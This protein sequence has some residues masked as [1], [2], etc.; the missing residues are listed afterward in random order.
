MNELNVASFF[1]SKT[2]LRTAIIGSGQIGTDL[3]FKVKSSEIL[4]PACLIGRSKN[5]RGLG[6]ARD[7]GV[8]S[9]SEGIDFLKEHLNQIDLLFDASSA[10]SHPEHYRLLKPDGIPVIDLTPAKLGLLCVPTINLNESKFRDNI[11]MITCGGQASLPMVASVSSA[12]E[13]VDYIEVVSSISA[14][15]AGLATRLNLDEYITTTESA[16]R[17]FGS[18]GNVKAILNIN[19][20]KPSVC[21]QTT[22]YIYTQSPDMDL[23]RDVVQATKIEVQKYVPGYDVILGPVMD[24]GRLTIILKVIGKGD[25]LPSYSGNLDIINCAAIAVAENIFLSGSARGSHE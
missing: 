20:A 22:I 9:S 11:N 5:S 6:I 25:Y 1:Q 3:L 8:E 12:L 19:P 17:Y 10:Q 16:L 7:L 24:K 13:T 23:I 21:M 18:T 2:K 15:S 14:D 4:K